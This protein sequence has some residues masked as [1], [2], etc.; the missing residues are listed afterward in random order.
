MTLLTAK[1][2]NLAFELPLEN[3]S[4]VMT[5]IAQIATKVKTIVL[6]AKMGIEPMAADVI[7]AW[8][9]TAQNAQ[10]LLQIV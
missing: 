5:R 10:F 7:V 4:H 9:P 8:L 3:V 1:I 6:P 2:V